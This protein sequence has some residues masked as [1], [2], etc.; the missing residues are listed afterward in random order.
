MSLKSKQNRSH[1][2]VIG[3]EAAIVMIAFVI[4]AAAL[5]YV[6]LNMGL[7]TTQQAKQAVTS[8]LQT[9]SGSLQIS[10]TILGIGHL[11]AGVLN[12]TDIPITIAGSNGAVNLDPSVT[13][14]SYTANGIQYGNIYKTSA[15]LLN[16]G[17]QASIN[18]TL[19]QAVASGCI[20]AN[21]MLT[22]GGN[23]PAATS[24]IVY[25]ITQKN[26]NTI[27]EAGENAHVLIVYAKVDRPAQTNS[28]K[29]E[30]TPAAGSVL[31]IERTIP[32]IIGTYVDMG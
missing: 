2:G 25:F 23:W 5:S 6:A 24:A 12:A 3:I 21:P 17:V 18:A 9:V 1:R 26:T 16:N 14:I 27:L 11:T 32:P 19:Q 20:N 7:S 10:D 13:T 8:S 15:C 28:F 30:L 29:A 4:V 22:V 31:T